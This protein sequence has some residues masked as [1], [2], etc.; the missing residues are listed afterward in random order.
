MKRE[1]VRVELQLA[2]DGGHLRRDSDLSEITPKV[3]EDH[4]R[5]NLPDGTIGRGS[6]GDNGSQYS[7]RN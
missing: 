5:A 4:I 1:S 2:A 3:P 6:D 7:R